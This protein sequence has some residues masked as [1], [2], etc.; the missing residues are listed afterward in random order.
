M[1]S[2]PRPSQL[3]RVCS[4][5]HDQALKRLPRPTWLAEGSLLDNTWLVRT[6]DP[7]ARRGAT[8]TI[9]FDVPVAPGPVRLTDPTLEHDLL[10]AKL[11]GYYG[12]SSSDGWHSNGDSAALDVKNLLTLIRWRLDR[13]ISHMANLTLDWFEEY[14]ETLRTSGALGLSP[15][16]P[17]MLAYLADVK[18]GAKSFPT[19]RKGLKINVDAQAVYEALGFAN[20]RQVSPAAREALRSAA[21]AEGL[22]L[23]GLD[24]ASD[25]KATVSEGEQVSLSATRMGPLLAVWE[26]LYALRHRMLHDSLGFDPFEAG[27][28]PYRLAQALG[29]RL[30]GRTRTLPAEQACFLVDRALRWVLAYADDLRSLHQV[31]HASFKAQSDRKDWNGRVK[32]AFRAAMKEFRPLQISS[33]APG[34]PWPLA[35]R[36]Q[37]GSRTQA[38]LLPDGMPLHTVFLELLPAAVAIVIATF[39]AR[40]REEV[41]S[42]RPGCIVRGEGGEAWLRT[43]IGK[44]HRDVDLI[45]V[46]EVVAKSVEVLEW[47]G[48]EGQGKHEWLFDLPRMLST[49][50]RVR[51]Q[52]IRK[53]DQFASFVGMPP[54]PD[55]TPWELAPHQLRRFFAITYY[56]RYR[57]PSLTALSDFLR[58]N[59]PDVTRRYITETAGG[60]LV[61]MAEERRVMAKTRTESTVIRRRQ[62]AFDDFEEVR[63]EFMIERFRNVAMGLETMGGFGGERLKAE[64]QDLVREAKRLVEVRSSRRESVGPTF[65]ELLVEFVKD[66]RMEPHGLGHSYCKCTSHEGDL[67]TAAC[68]TA[69]RQ[70][71]RDTTRDAGPDHTF[72]V[73]MTC[74]SCPHNIQMPENHSYW[75]TQVAVDGA[76]AAKAPTEQLRLLACQRAESGRRHIQRC[77]L[78]AGPLVEP[79]PL[80]GAHAVPR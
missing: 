31:L 64:V 62:G 30:P 77:F 75:E 33:G 41:E 68:L 67:A 65:D 43:W 49:E 2:I 37:V 70:A 7:A 6:D 26:R 34:A 52:L 44:S 80:E 51:F 29:A 17:R 50:H 56:W 25:R 71:G 59:D 76:I 9:R 22:T 13:G 42:L 5:I 1:Q 74:S 46:P 27:G 35:E 21:E 32:A 73:D 47:L 57:Y 79:W 53:L 23:R 15:S 4:S 55:G 16:E 61:R 24:S 45:P 10:T 28:T 58:H 19:K 14:C 60:G 63:R 39:S 69:K 3:P 78:Q 8:M 40:R 12:L 66:R 54:S 38:L 18:S 11:Y 72:A 36:I 48:S 20:A